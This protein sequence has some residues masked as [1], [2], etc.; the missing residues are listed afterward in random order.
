VF[1]RGEFSAKIGGVVLK[2]HWRGLPIYTLTLEERA[3]CPRS[4]AHWLNCY[5]NNSPYALR[6]KAGAELESRV[7]GEMTDLCALHPEGVAVRLHNLGD[8]YSIAYV[9][10]WRTLIERHPR[11][12][13]F[14]FTAR[15]D[16]AGDAIAIE[17]A[18]L[19]ADHWPRFAIRA[20]NGTGM[21]RA[22]VSIRSAAEKPADAIICPQQQ[23]K[24]ESCS[25]CAL[26]WQSERR[27]AFLEH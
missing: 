2:G 15:T 14:G 27:I 5:G 7:V 11:L 4:C 8:F 6:L 24:T 9:R 23:N 13:V 20:S 21:Q 1:K 26:C 19:V 18:A 25:T 12:H 22:T 16:T 17:L 3:T 10:L